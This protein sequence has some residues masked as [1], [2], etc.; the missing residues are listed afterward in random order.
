MVPVYEIEIDETLQEINSVSLQFA[1]IG[2]DSVDVTHRIQVLGASGE[3]LSERQV[4]LEQTCVF[5]PCPSNQ[6]YL[7][8]APYHERGVQLVIR[9]INSNQ[10]VTYDIRRYNNYCGDGVCSTGDTASSCPQD[11]L[12][13]VEYFEQTSSTTWLWATLITLI[14]VVLVLLVIRKKPSTPNV[15]YQ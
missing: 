3:T 14:L 4:N 13:T 15:Q 8:Y 9:E 2:D 12:V 7:V 11:C 6:P 5:T 1:L 10:R